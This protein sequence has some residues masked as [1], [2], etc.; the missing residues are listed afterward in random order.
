MAI[1][2]STAMLEYLDQRDP[3]F[4][5]Y[6]SVEES[7][8]VHYCEKKPQPLFSLKRFVPFSNIGTRDPL[9]SAFLSSGMNPPDDCVEPQWTWGEANA[10][11]FA[12]ALAKNCEI[13]DDIHDDAAWTIAWDWTEE[14]FSRFIQ[15]TKVLSF[16]EAIDKIPPATSTGPVMRKYFQSGTELAHSI[17]GKWYLATHWDRAKTPGGFLTVWGAFCKHE[18]KPLAKVLLG[19]VRMFICAP[20][21]HFVVNVAL[22]H[23]FNSQMQSHSDELEFPSRIGTTNHGIFFSKM[24]RWVKNEDYDPI[25][26][27]VGGWDARLFYLMLVGAA[28]L[29]YNMMSSASRTPEVLCMISNTYRDIAKTPLMLPNGLVVEVGG[30]PSGQYNTAHDNTIILHVVWAWMYFTLVPEASFES[31]RLHLRLNLF[32]DDSLVGVHKQIQG[33]INPSSIKKLLQS[34]RWEVEFSPYAEFLGHYAQT[35]PTRD[36]V[37]P[38]FPR[39]KAYYVLAFDDCWDWSLTM[40]KA[41]SVRTLC[42]TDPE[43]FQF[44]DAYCDFLFKMAPKAD[45]KLLHLWEQRITLTYLENS[46]Y[47]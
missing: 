36:L 47:A 29:R 2:P 5:D 34:L 11:N 6:G 28:V 18:L 31:F 3:L 44:V 45:V 21:E 25:A 32:G 30:Q 23:D 26:M 38:V 33:Y 17:F 20:K 7:E 14:V 39:N 9:F 35:D 8:Y 24:L 22:S 4:K 12:R 42:Y 19:K 37:I 15:P 13:R 10:E 1:E 41:L 27:D 40:Q 46:L 16:M 43:M